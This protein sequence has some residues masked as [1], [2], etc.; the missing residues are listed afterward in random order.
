[1]ICGI[2]SGLFASHRMQSTTFQKTANALGSVSGLAL[3]V[4]SAVFSTTSGGE[5]AKP[6]QQP[7]SFYVGVLLPCLGGLIASNLLARGARLNK[8]EVV[9]LSVECCYQNVG[10]A[11]SAALGMFDDPKE[12]AQALAVPLCYGL[13]EAVVLGVYCLLAWKLGWTKAPKEEKIC[14]VLT[15]TFEIEDTE[16]ENE[17]MASVEDQ[18][19][20]ESMD[21]VCSMDR[22]KTSDSGIEEDVKNREIERLR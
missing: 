7:W 2:V 20:I 1:M 17:S 22:T 4:F 10:I 21:M 11:T 8:P 16:E 18:D 13:M 19:V 6:W 3:I 15:K 5:D 12:I 9:T 14:I